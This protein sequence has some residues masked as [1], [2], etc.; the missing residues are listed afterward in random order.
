MKLEKIMTA[1]GR[2]VCVVV[3]ASV[4]MF[5]AS[6]GKSS[7]TGPSASAVSTAV[8]GPVKNASGAPLTIGYIDEG[9]SA[10]IDARPEVAAA[11]TAANY[12]NN[13]LGGVAGR[14]LKLLT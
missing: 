6:C 11:Q 8:L 9:Q 12:V 10:G 7:P 13:Y 2:R 4:A 5:C 14:P 1:R 3:V